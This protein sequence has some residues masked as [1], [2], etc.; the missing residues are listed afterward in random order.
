MKGHLLF[1]PIILIL[2]LLGAVDLWQNYDLWSVHNAVSEFE[3]QGY[4][5]SQW[6]VS[7]DFNDTPYLR[8]IGLGAAVSVATLSFLSIQVRKEKIHTTYQGAKHL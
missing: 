1:V 8:L 3:F 4:T 5:P 2:I 7:N 6:V